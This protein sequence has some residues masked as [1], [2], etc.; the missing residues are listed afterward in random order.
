MPLASGTCGFCNTYLAGQRTRG[1]YDAP[2]EE[3]AGDGL[4]LEVTS[5]TH[6]TQAA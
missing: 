2:L 3:E 6:F 5:T 4:L 1:P